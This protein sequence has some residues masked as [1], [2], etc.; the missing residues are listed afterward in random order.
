MAPY[1]EVLG[2]DPMPPLGHC[3]LYS[4]LGMNESTMVLMRSMEQGWT[5][6][7]MYSM[8]RRV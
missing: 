1:G 8:A 2:F 5:G 3:P 4:H 7:D 6:R